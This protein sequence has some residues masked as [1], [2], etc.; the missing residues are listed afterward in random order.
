MKLYKIILTIFLSSFVFVATGF[1]QEL[2]VIRIDS[3]II[4][5]RTASKILMERPYT[6]PVSI[7]PSVSRLSRID[8]RKTGAT[9]V[10]DAMQ[11]IPGALI[12]TRGRQVK[13]FFSVRGQKYPYPDY[14]INGVWQKE[15]EELPYFFS[16]SDI[17]DIEIVR[18]SAALLTGL[19]GLTGLVN[20]KT[21]EYTSAETSIEAEYGSFNT[22]HTHVSNG[23]KIGN[24]NY[25]AGLG[26]DRTSGPEGKHAAEEMANLYTQAGWQPSDKLNVKASVYMMNGERQMRI[27][28]LPADKRYRDMV[29]YFDPVRTILSNVKTVYRPGD[30]YSSEVQVFYSRRSPVFH[31]E[32]KQTSSK[33][34][35]YEYGLNLMQSAALT[36]LNVLRF[37]G[38]Y[39]RWIAPN[40][41]RFYMGKRCDVETFSGVIVDE[42]RLGRLTLDAGVRWTRSYLNDYGAFNIEG[43]GAQFR[44]VTPVTDEWEAPVIQG[45]LGA[46]YNAGE[47]LSFFF[48]SAAGQVK[49][50]RGSLDV[51]FITPETEKR[52][53]LDLGI[54]AKIPGVADITLTGFS[55]IQNDA[56]VLSGTS[57]LDTA[58]NIRREL[59]ENR[60]Q[61]Q[62]GVELDLKG[63]DIFGFIRPFF[64]LTYMKSMMMDEGNKV[65]NKENPEFIAAGGFFIEKGSFDVN[66]LGKYVS[67]F[68]NDRFAVPADGPQPL[69]DYFTLDAIAGYTMKGKFPARFYLKA[70]NL[71]DKRYS[72]V[73][74]YPDFGRMLHAGIQVRFN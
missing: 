40:G 36:P 30:R 38:L 55:V 66:V 48:N 27:A 56:I 26:Y 57:Y 15:F 64:N 62:G 54:I 20:I 50:K 28:E 59:Y 6:E 11:Y 61:D 16:T 31:D 70:R 4:R 34:M 72:T 5:A 10:V 60:D 18:S 65:R 74:G 7:Q 63:G 71:T 1:S 47:R 3:V 33:E 32:V 22:L 13:Q 45:S 39:N 44:N 58:T 2:D 42:Q 37:G 8:I 19:S 51:D 14:A 24:F 53:K 67:A 73:I 17:E 25:A 21:R 43:D 68:E 23:N 41:K 35:D 46:S 52:Y 69:G 29:Q 9:N 49:P 12:E